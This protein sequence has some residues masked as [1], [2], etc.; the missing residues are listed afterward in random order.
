MTKDDMQKGVSYT[1]DV[2]TYASGKEENEHLNRLFDD[3]A[4]QQDWWKILSSFY[5]R[6][7][8]KQ[9]QM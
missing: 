4:K 3:L 6:V 5:R 2:N 8:A 9:K 7:S 1:D